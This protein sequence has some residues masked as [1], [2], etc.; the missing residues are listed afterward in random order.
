MA[1][2]RVDIVEFLRLA[3]RLSV[4][5]V[6]SPGEYSRAHIPGAQSLPL[7]DDEER[8]VIGTAY[9]Q[10]SREQAIKIGLEA[11]GKKMVALVEQAE[12]MTGNR[13]KEILVHCWRGGMRS[14]AVAWL[15]DLYGF[16]VY[17]LSG[18]YKSFRRYALELFRTQWKMNILGGYTG[19]NKTGVIV[20]MIAQGMQAIDL[21]ALAGHKGSAFG[22]LLQIPQPTQE[23]FENLLAFH[24]HRQSVNGRPFW[25][26]AESQRIGLVNIPNDFFLQMRSSPMFFIDI[27]FSKRLGHILAEYGTFDKERLV[28]AVLRVQKKLGGLEA[29]N[30]VTFLLEDNVAGCFTIMLKYYDKLYLKSTKEPLAKAG[31][32]ISPRP[33]TYIECDDT[34]AGEN[35][36]A[37]LTHVP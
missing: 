31:P 23:H 21:E 19:S 26:E 11:F 37:L 22:N 5:D 1:V 27:P 3:E 32:A 14:G 16:R 9:K 24:L 6:R 10:E 30:A 28:G 33:V 17:I 15:L 20:K 34:S 8:R 4:A 18:G 35:L 13:N 2:V 25:L 29:K 7:F 36:A 12:S